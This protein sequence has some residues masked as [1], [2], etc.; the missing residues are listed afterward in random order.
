LTFKNQAQTVTDVD[1][2]VYQTVTIATQVWMKENLRTTKYND[3]T[4]IPNITDDAV[5]KSL[6]TGAYCD[7]T[8]TPSTSVVYGRLYNWYAVSPGTNG[9]RNLCPT[10]WHVP[11]DS[12]WNILEKYLD[13]TVDTTQ[14][15]FSGVDIG[16][17]LKES[18]TIHWA[19]GNNGTNSSNFTALPGGYRDIY[20]GTFVQII[21]MGYWW[22]NTTDLY[23]GA[24]LV[25]GHHLEYYKSTVGRSRNF[26][27]HGFSVR[28]VRDMP[29][30]INDQTWIDQNIKI[31]PNPAFDRVYIDYS[32]YQGL[33]IIVYNLF[34]D[35]VF[36]DVLTKGVNEIDI[37]TLTSGVYFIRVTGPDG[38]IQRKLIKK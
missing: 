10:N 36:Q 12:E 3:G 19:V 2:N 18:G 21:Q 32:E 7:Y 37:S 14:S 24:T 33:E 23:N 25:W 31:Y 11:N 22:T 6:T 26:M 8:N 30:N 35:C 13:Y 34:G 9:G 29:S 27:E 20:N 5:W 28:C 4:S 1:G 38:A 17:K 15:G 16:D